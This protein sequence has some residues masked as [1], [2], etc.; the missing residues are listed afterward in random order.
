M[1]DGIA[2]YRDG[3]PMLVWD[4]VESKA[5]VRNVVLVKP[6]GECLAFDP[7][8]P[9]DIPY[10]DLWK[11]YKKVP[12]KRYMTREEATR[13]LILMPRIAVRT[14]GGPWRMPGQFSLRDTTQYE[15]CYVN[16]SGYGIP[17]DFLTEEMC[18]IS[19]SDS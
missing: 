4:E 17:H 11:H 2:D 15:W 14:K 16:T 6:T 18:E 12:E 9:Y 19:T 10:L 8:S 7:D 13:F 3:K 1:T 5:V